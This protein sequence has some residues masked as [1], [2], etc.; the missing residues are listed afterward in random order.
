MHYVVLVLLST[1][2]HGSDIYSFCDQ[3]YVP[4]TTEAKNCIE[5]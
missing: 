2:P 1:E 3:M 5:A 4:S